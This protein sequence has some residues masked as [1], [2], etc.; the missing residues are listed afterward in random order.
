MSQTR[1]K[2]GVPA[3]LAVQPGDWTGRGGPSAAPSVPLLRPARRQPSVTSMSS[4]GVM[5]LRSAAALPPEGDGAGLAEAAEE[6]RGRG[7][8]DQQP[9]VLGDQVR[10][11]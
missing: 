2:G 3:P 7:D 9:A 8:D 11:D 5:T 1:R 10:H 4:G 6:D